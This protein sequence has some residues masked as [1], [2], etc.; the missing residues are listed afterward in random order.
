EAK[1][2]HDTSLI[3][4]RMGDIRSAKATLE[5]ALPMRQA[6]VY[7]HAPDQIH[8]LAMTLNDLG[9]AMIR[10][11]QRKEG[12]RLLE[13]AREHRQMLTSIDKSNA[14][15]TLWLAKSHH[16]IGNYHAMADPPEY[17]L[18]LASYSLVLNVLDQAAPER[19]STADF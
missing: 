10:L 7:H 17:D 4:W 3:Y 8:D 5:T 2:L 9:M 16:N 13:Q 19:R 1:I 6:I 18:A 15:Y 14:T 11:N 12:L